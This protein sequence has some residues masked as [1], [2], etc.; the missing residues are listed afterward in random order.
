MNRA[1]VT[2]G[3]SE[4]ASLIPPESKMVGAHIIVVPA[5]QYISEVTHIRRD[6]RGNVASV[7]VKLN[8]TQMES[9]VPLG[10]V[11]WHWDSKPGTKATGLWHMKVP[12]DR[13]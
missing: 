7:S 12:E 8:A 10:E 9:E 6:E 5:K 3:L 2:T 13:R 11:Q 1:L 4:K